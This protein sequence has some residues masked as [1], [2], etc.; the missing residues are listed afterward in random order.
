MKSINENAPVKCTQSIMINAAPEKV[1]QTLTNI[2]RWSQWQSE[3][4]FAEFKGTL[5]TGKKFD[6]KTGGVTIHSTIHTARPNESFGWT[7]KTIGLY[8]I[9]NWSL[10]KLEAGTEVTVAESLEG[11]LAVLLKGTFNKNLQTG[12]AKWL[13]LLKI[14]CEKTL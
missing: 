13:N 1:W 9:H 6:W 4:P 11:W 10:K 7:G 3:I 2:N 8:A 14:E 5:Q 12:M